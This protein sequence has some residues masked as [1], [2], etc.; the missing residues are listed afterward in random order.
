MYVDSIDDLATLSADELNAVV[1][2]ED[3]SIEVRRTARQMWRAL[4]ESLPK[5]ALDKTIVITPDLSRSPV[6]DT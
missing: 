4:I 2:N 1:R 5:A 3:N 6:D